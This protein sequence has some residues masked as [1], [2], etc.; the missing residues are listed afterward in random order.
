MLKILLKG[1]DVAIFAEGPF[2]RLEEDDRKAYAGYALVAREYKRVTGEDLPVVPTGIRGK[3]VL[4]GESF[5]VDSD[6][7]QTTAQLEDVAT[8]KIHGLYDSLE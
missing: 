1:E 3:K 8:E 2:S 6:G 7:R 4:F 5:S